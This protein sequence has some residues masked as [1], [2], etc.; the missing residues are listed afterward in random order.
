MDGFSG[1]TGEAALE[2]ARRLSLTTSGRSQAYALSLVLGLLLMAAWL[3]SGQG[4]A[5]PDLLRPLH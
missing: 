3:L 2:G 1:A 4:S 5:T